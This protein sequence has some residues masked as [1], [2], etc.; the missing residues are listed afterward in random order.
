[1]EQM[2]LDEYS[3][4]WLFM[5]IICATTAVATFLYLFYE[6]PIATLWSFV[7]EKLTGK[8]RTKV[9]MT[10]QTKTELENKPINQKL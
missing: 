8:G 2:Y 10:Q 5:S 1:M 4:A 7:M 9:D 3:F 6:M